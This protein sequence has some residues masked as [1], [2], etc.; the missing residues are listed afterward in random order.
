MLKLYKINKF[1][2]KKV[3]LAIDHFVLFQVVRV[4]ELYYL[5]H[6]HGLA[7]FEEI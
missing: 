3:E 5:L 4:E 2:Q 7:N 1:K 6:Y